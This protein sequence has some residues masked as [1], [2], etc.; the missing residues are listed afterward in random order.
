MTVDYKKLFEK[1]EAQL[2]RETEW[3]ADYE[4]IKEREFEHIKS[5]DVKGKD[6][7]EYLYNEKYESELKR[8]E[9]EYWFAHGMFDTY[10]KLTEYIDDLKKE[11]IKNID[12]QMEQTMNKVMEQMKPYFK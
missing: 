12:K 11:E 4:S 3:A 1:F 2:K 6:G 8:V 10:K 7:N 5:R 9:A